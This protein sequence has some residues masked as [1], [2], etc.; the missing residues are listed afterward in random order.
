MI[1]LI[2]GDAGIGKTFL[3]CQAFSKD[4]P[5][6]AVCKLDLR[7]LYTQWQSE[8]L[9][10]PRP[11]LFAGTSAGSEG[12]VILSQLL[13]IREDQPLPLRRHLES[14]PASFYVIDSLDEIHPDDCE[15]VLEQIERF[16]HDSARPFL[17]VV[18]LGRSVAFRDFWH[19]RAG[20]YSRDIMDLYLL[21][22]PQL[23]TTGDLLVSTWNYHSFFFKLQV[24]RDD[25]EPTGMPFDLYR[26]WTQAGFPASINGMQVQHQANANMHPKVLDQVQTWAMRYPVVNSMLYN[27][28]GNGLIREIAERHALADKPYDERQVMEE[29]LSLW[30]DRDTQSNDRPSQ[31]KPEH[32]DLYLRLLEGVAVKYLDEGQ[33]DNAG[34]FTI[35]YDD[36]IVVQERGRTLRFPVYRIVD[37][38][39]LKHADPRDPGGPRYRFEPFW[40]HRLLVQK[41]NDRQRGGTLAVVSDIT[42]KEPAQRS[43]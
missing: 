27:L 34:Y 21:D 38:S 5:R 12:D 20:F 8:G 13:A 33:L 40:V 7:E 23:R 24:S 15:R 29:Y 43:Q 22:P 4:Y 31:A 16:V 32:L 25:A 14:V 9:V 19:K 17:H 6:E 11:D 3:K 30:L 36:A 28:A 2:A 18:V 35:R 26:Q 41:H 1:T 37:R 10:E 39:G 42:A